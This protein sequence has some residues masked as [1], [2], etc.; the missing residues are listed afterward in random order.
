M[1]LTAERIIEELGLEPHPEGGHYRETFRDANGAGA[2]AHSTAILYLLRESEVAR[3]H[4][5]D[6]T[7]LWHWYGGAPL[8]LEM[9]T[10]GSARKALRLGPDWLKER[11][12]GLVPPYAWQ[13]A[14]SLGAWTLAGCTVAP[15][16]GLLQLRAGP[17]R[18]RTMTPLPSG[19]RAFCREFARAK[20]LRK[21]H[22][23]KGEGEHKCI[24]GTPL[25]GA[26]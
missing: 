1:D 5:I 4:R 9:T 23:R 12:Q 21:A 24:V 15:G 3:W 8:L 7:E 19:E 13:T 11:P 16:F 20:L 6:A 26:Y 18:L 10:D 22:G 14:R 17:Q 25:P 2:R